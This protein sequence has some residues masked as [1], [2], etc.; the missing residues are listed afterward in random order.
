MTRRLMAGTAVL[1]VMVSATSPAARSQQV[2]NS[3][4]VVRGLYAAFNTQD[5]TALVAHVSDDIRWMQVAGANV[6]VEASGRDALR[7]AMTRYFRSTPT[8]RSRIEKLMSAGEYVT[9]HERVTWMQGS[10]E[11]TQSAVAVYQLRSARIVSVWYFG[12]MP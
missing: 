10:T 9:V 8:A 4:D 12:V 1:L 5:T 7:D 6:A 3:E 11:N 2:F